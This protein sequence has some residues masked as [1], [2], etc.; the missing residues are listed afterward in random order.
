[1]YSHIHLKRPYRLHNHT[2]NWIN[3]TRHLD[4]VFIRVRKTASESIS[5]TIIENNNVNVKRSPPYT[6]CGRYGYMPHVSALYIKK[7]FPHFYRKSYK[8]AFIRNPYD[9]F[10]SAFY[11]MNQRRKFHNPDWV[12][13]SLED[14]IDRVCYNNEMIHNAFEDQHLLVTDDTN[15]LTVDNLY[16]YEELL[17]SWEDIKKDN[18]Y[19]R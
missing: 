1:M 19:E 11:Y 13:V 2:K 17:N 7:H 12:D 4:I 9:R 6:K 3:A 15:K 18:W 10:L 14:T 8:F 16:R 5:N